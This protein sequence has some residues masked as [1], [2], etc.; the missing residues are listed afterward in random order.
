MP[1]NFTQQQRKALLSALKKGRKNAIGAKPLAQL[2]GFSI[3]SN[4]VQ[5]RSLIKECIE[6]DGDLIGSATGKPA[7]FFIIS[8]LD[9]L[10]KYLDSL[11]HRTRSD[12]TR[13]TAL[14]NNWNNNRQGSKKTNRPP[15][16]I[17]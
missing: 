7:G 16:T 15:L 4:Q 3:R 17:R 5:L 12:N 8:T 11:E 14:I 9:E 1:T 10:E 2:L 13:R 6:Q